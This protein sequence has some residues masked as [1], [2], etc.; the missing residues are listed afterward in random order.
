MSDNQEL[1]TRLGRLATQISNTLRTSAE[2]QRPADA[3]L[4][5]LPPSISTRKNASCALIRGGHAIIWRIWCHSN[6]RTRRQLRYV[7][8]DVMI[9]LNGLQT[10]S[11][12]MYWGPQ[13]ASVIRSPRGLYIVTSIDMR[14][15]LGIS[16]LLSQPSVLANT[17]WLEID[18]QMTHQTFSSTLGSR[19][20]YSFPTLPPCGWLEDNSDAARSVSVAR[21]LT[22]LKIIS[23]FHSRLGRPSSVLP[24]ALPPGLFARGS[25][26]SECIL[27]NV[28]YPNRE[29]MA[30]FTVLKN[31]A[32]DSTSPVFSEDLDLL[33]SLSPALRSLSIGCTEFNTRP[34]TCNQ[35]LDASR[36]TKACVRLTGPV[37]PNG[38]NTFLEYCINRGMLDITAQHGW[39]KL[40]AMSDSLTAPNGLACTVSGIS[41]TYEAGTSAW[42]EHSF[43]N[44]S[45]NSR[46]RFVERSS[47][48]MAAEALAHMAYRKLDLDHLTSL[49]LHEKIF[50]RLA[51][52]NSEISPWAGLFAMQPPIWFHNGLPLPHVLFPPLPPW[53]VMP[54][55][56]ELLPEFSR[57]PPLIF[58]RVKKVVIWLSTCNEGRAIHGDDGFTS[59]FVQAHALS[60]APPRFDVLEELVISVASTRIGCDTRDLVGTSPFFDYEV[61]HFAR[62]TSCT[63]SPGMSIS[64]HD[65][66]QMLQ[67]LQLI[68]DRLLIHLQGFTIVDVD[69]AKALIALQAVVNSVEFSSIPAACDLNGLPSKGFD[70]ESIFTALDG[71]RS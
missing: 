59:I 25:S 61:F 53:P 43:Q 15:H 19:R 39:T 2:S 64:L 18:I 24:L 35:V 14:N 49:S 31:F 34:G 42:V 1:Q 56:S 55:P 60:T 40:G 46:I 70:A 57:K 26:L 36:I 48:G 23:G 66:L 3:R 13:N 22:R 50:M 30:T 8:R 62:N 45:K 5:A 37:P 17:R 33:I 28:A 47:L 63:C 71:N 38:K 54:P 58:P 20:R 52:Y 7:C 69:A 44:S 51:G 21:H 68:H 12:G 9:Q 65:T 10:K 11:G 32:F 27:Q 41:L 29:V 4:F 67:R 16:R 6:A